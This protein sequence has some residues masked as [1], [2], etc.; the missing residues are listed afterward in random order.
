MKAL[1][2]VPPDTATDALIRPTL[3]VK[4]ACPGVLAETL[5]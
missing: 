5:T 2:R 1:E 3:N 4:S